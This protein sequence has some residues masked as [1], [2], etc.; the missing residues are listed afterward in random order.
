MHTVTIEIERI[1][2]SPGNALSR[3]LKYNLSCDDQPSVTLEID[4]DQNMFNE[5]K[6]ML[7]YDKKVTEETKLA[8]IDYLGKLVTDILNRISPPIAVEINKHPDEAFHLHLLLNAK[9][10]VQLPFEL[11]LNP[12]GVAGQPLVPF[13]LN[14]RR[15][16]TL[17]RSVKQT[18]TAAYLWPVNTRILFVSAEPNETVPHDAHFAL[19][20]DIVKELAEPDSTMPEPVADIPSMLTVQKKASLK[21]IREAIQLGINDQRPYT[22]I[23]LL[24][25]GSRDEASTNPEEY[26]V[27]LHDDNNPSE[28]FYATGIELAGAILA[29]DGDTAVVPAI[30][31]LMVCDSGNTGN[32]SLPAGSVANQLHEAGIPCVFASQFPLS[33]VGSVKLVAALY[34]RLLLKGDDPRRALYFTRKDLIDRKNHDWASL[35]V[36]VRFPDDIDKQMR[37]Y[38]L[39]VILKLLET[40]SAWAEHLLKHKP[41][42]PSEKFIEHFDKICGRLTNSINEINALFREGK[43]AKLGKEYYAEQSGLIAS[44]YKREA[45]HFFRLA[46]IKQDMKDTLF[47]KSKHSLQ[48]ARD[49]YL[50]GFR[51][52]R[53]SYWNG[54]QYL[55]LSGIM[56][57]Y[58]D[59]EDDKDYF[60]VIRTMAKDAF[61]NEQLNPIDKIWAAG[62][63]ME[64]YLLKPLIV[65]DDQFIKEAESCL[66]EAKKYA[67][68]VG[69]AGSEF[70]NDLRI[71]KKEIAFAR[72]STTRQLKRY[73]YWWPQLYPSARLL[74]LEKMAAELL[75]EFKE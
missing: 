71:T 67:R 24:A 75:E 47:N 62:T 21:S 70:I 35:V 63:L 7:R 27:A 8:G 54:I 36:H 40:S 53:D 50:V 17:T 41:D 73:V 58:I 44:A 43:V 13:L 15:V 52:V 4:S 64:L 29:I 3:D 2:P 74:R 37:T 59:G 9:E 48:S 61:E 18:G 26:K 20:R 38:R 10:L 22:H 34:N 28:A 66:P 55:A 49:W 42:I 5:K 72:Q 45:E 25:H 1:G 23:H 31:S 65:T 32:I 19:L 14:Q 6:E 57:G 11:A 16:I 68:S 51:A 56:K 39:R 69:N 60:G 30:V 12:A 46:D 33:I